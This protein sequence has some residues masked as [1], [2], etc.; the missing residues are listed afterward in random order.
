MVTSTG[1]QVQVRRSDQFGVEV[2]PAMTNLYPVATQ[3]GPDRS[4]LAPDCYHF[5]T[6]LHSLVGNIVFI[7]L[8]RFTSEFVVLNVFRWERTYGTT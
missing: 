1:K 3:G 7:A 5:N 2:L 6:K 4:F 8:L